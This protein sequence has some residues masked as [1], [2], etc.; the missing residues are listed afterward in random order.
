MGMVREEEGNTYR[1]LGNFSNIV[2]D[3]NTLWVLLEEL[4]GGRSIHILHEQSILGGD[5]CPQV[6][7]HGKS[8][9]SQSNVQVM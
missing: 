4:L 7:S 1:F 6:L 8:Y 3:A 5:L 2:R 9:A